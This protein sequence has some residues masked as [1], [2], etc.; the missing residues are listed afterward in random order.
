MA[1]DQVRSVPLCPVCGEPAD[2]F[3]IADGG[4]CMD[5]VRARAASVAANGRCRCPKAKQQPR[6]VTTRSRS[7]V[8]CDRCLGSIRQIS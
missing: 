8:A 7:W 4:P 2:L 3:A 6:T 5:C 1:E